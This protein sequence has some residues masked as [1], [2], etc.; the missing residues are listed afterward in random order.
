MNTTSQKKETKKMSRKTK[1][2]LTSIIIICIAALTLGGTIAYWSAEETE[3]NVITAG[4]I[5]MELIEQMKDPETGELIPF[6]NQDGIMPGSICSK[7]V[8]VKNTGENDEFVR[9]KVEKKIDIKDKEEEADTDLLIIDFDEE[10]WILKDGFYYYYRALK[11]GEITEEPL[12]TQVTFSE[13]MG[14]LYQES[15]ATITVQGFAVQAANNGTDPLKA[16]GWP[17]EKPEPETE[18]QEQN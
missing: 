2:L 18:T 9:I 1:A 5:K 8:Q 15:V 3:T 7:I 10:H 16:E 12:F 17:K 4:S 6:E 14:N 11:S 13:D